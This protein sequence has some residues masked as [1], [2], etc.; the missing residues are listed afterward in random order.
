MTE[1]LR[2]EISDGKSVSAIRTPPKGKHAG[3]L[4]IYAPGAGSNMHDPFGAFA[5]HELAAHGVEFVRIQFPYMEAGKRGPDRPP[6]LEATWRAAIEALRSNDT[7]LIVGGRSM[8]GRI[9]S[10]VVAQGTQVDALALYAYPLHAPGKPD[11]WRDKHLSEIVAP[12][13]FCSGTRDAFAK[14]EELETVASKMAAA[15]LHLLEHA[16][17][18]FAAPKSSGRTR[19]DIWA[20]AVEALLRWLP[21]AS[22]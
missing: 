4:F 1:Q 3:W 14:P 6:V 12:A 22:L 19:D 15:R 11:R 13:L 9:A 10:Q 20:E 5:S 18:G 21:D 8:G 7:K 16:D 2:I 17:H